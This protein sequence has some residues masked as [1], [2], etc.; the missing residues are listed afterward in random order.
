MHSRGKSFALLKPVKNPNYTQKEIDE[1][2]DT[3]LS[4]AEAMDNMDVILATS[5]L[6]Y[7]LQL[8]IMPYDFEMFWQLI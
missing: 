6:P 1:K 7:N 5:F 4:I 3:R 8:L 2:T